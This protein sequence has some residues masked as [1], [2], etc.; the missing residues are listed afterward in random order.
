MSIEGLWFL[1]LASTHNPAEFRHGGIVML[2]SKRVVGADSI[3]S[4]LGN[5]NVNDEELS[6]QIRVQTWNKDV[7]SENIFGMKEPIDYKVHVSGRRQGNVILGSLTTIESPDLMLP[8][9][10]QLIAD[11]P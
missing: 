5:Y 3:C 11:L 4:Y 6:G 8:F 9:R 10:M 7:P 2:E 1:Q